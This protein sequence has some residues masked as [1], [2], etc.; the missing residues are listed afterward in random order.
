MAKKKKNTR[1]FS[2]KLLNKYRLVILNENTFEEQVSFKL[3]RLNVFILAGISSFLLVTGTIFLIVFSSLKEYIPGYSNTNNYNHQTT[4]LAYETDSLVRVAKINQKYYESIQKVLIGNIEHKDLSAD[5]LKYVS[6]LN[7]DSINTEPSEE[8][9]GLQQEIA[10]KEKFNI[11]TA[12]IDSE[13]LFFPPV[14]GHLTSTFS[15]KDK[16]YSVD[17]SVEDNTR[18]VAAA[19]GVVIFNEWNPATGNVIVI[20]HKSGLSSIYKHNSKIFKKQGDTVEA[21]EVI[22]IAGNTGELSTGPHLQFEL[23]DNQQPL[24][25]TKYID[26]EK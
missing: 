14:K 6:A 26:F 20:K 2:E 13:Y 15:H 21:G 11:N 4:Q 23:W 5:S 7:F 18:V 8:V 12:Q 17:I 16:H 1:S 10:Q 3:S 25:P 9:K 24:D 22:A 19:N